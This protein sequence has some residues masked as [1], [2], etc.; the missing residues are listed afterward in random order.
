MHSELYSSYHNVFLGES[1]C[2]ASGGEKVL[3]LAPILPLGG[4]PGGEGHGVELGGETVGTPGLSTEGLYGRQDCE[5]AGLGERGEG[6]ERW[7]L[8]KE[9]RPKELGAE[10]NRGEPREL[11][12]NKEG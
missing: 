4:V 3:K 9:G 6:R 10:T 8:R 11:G 1:K 2:I 12:V 5:S 7:D